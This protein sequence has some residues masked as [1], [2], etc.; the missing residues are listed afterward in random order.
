[1]IQ[2]YIAQETPLM[3]TS[4]RRLIGIGVSSQSS[5]YLK[6]GSKLMATEDDRFKDNFICPQMM[7]AG[8]VAGIGIAAAFGGG[9]FVLAAAA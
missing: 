9:L 1:M 3:C 6:N 8:A 7:I 5:V 2:L 4:G